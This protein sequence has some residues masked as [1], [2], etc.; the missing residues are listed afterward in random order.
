M[1]VL[2][3]FV[4]FCHFGLAFLL[5]ANRLRSPRLSLAKPMQTGPSQTSVPAVPAVP[6]VLVVVPARNE[7]NN[8]GDC[9]AS[10]LS[11][12]YPALTVR[13]VDDHSTDSTGQIA[14]VWA[15][16]DARL[17]VVQ[18]PPLSPGWLGKPH[19]VHHGVRGASA[20]YV[21][22][23]DADVRLTPSA[24]SRAVGLAEEKRAGLTTVMPEL[25]ALSFWERAT[26]PVIGLLLCGLLDPVKTNDPDRKEAAGFGP[27]M[28]FRK[29]AYDALGGHQAVAREVI[30]DL[31]L[32][33]LVKE[34]RLGL[35][36]AH[37]TEFVK[38]RMYD[39]LRSLVAGWSKNFHVVLGQARFLAPLFALMLAVV[40]AL[41]TCACVWAFVWRATGHPWPAWLLWA[42]VAYGFDALARGSL[43]WNYDVTPR[44]FRALGGVVTG[45]ILCNSAYRAALGRS[46]TWKDR[47]ISV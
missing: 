40:F 33:Q 37:G 12:D 18:P 30:E 6:S 21:L 45:Y 44:G 42:A 24:V 1:V 25:V 27:F 4:A 2:L 13:V 32:A 14:A 34:K 7:E 11:Q 36:V 23:V 10:I 35:C 43:F 5:W 28:L 22:F 8:L 31:R 19:A 26:Q 3:G 29:D 16:R 47:T 17:S 15:K 46:L 38:L 20:D 9:V 41:P 39:N